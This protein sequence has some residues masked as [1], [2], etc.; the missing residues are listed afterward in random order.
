ME[1]AIIDLPVA[2]DNRTM[3][4]MEVAAAIE[5]R[6]L[7][8]EFTKAVLVP[9]KDYGIIPGTEKYTLLKPGAEKLSSYFGFSVRF[10]ILEAEKDWTGEKHNHEPF[11]HYE[12]RCILYHGEK[13]IAEGF[14]ACNSWE[15]KFRYRSARRIC[16]LCQ[17]PA[18]IKSKYNGGFYCNPK[19]NGCGRKFHANDP[20]IINQEEGK[21]NNPDIADQVNTIL[22]I[23]KKRAFIDAI[24]IAVNASEFFTQDLED[25]EY[26]G[27]ASGETTETT[28]TPET[29]N[30]ISQLQAKLNDLKLIKYESAYFRYLREKY[31]LASAD[32]INQQQFQEQIGLLGQCE[33][34]KTKLK[35]LEK[36]LKNIN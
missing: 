9:N 11:F 5:R 13:I 34:N 4:V 33:G 10:E 28:T 32:D 36:Y 30:L 21:V 14:G 31:E 8:V 2:L 12:I 22:K 15:K 3:P 18:I 16:P 29:D 25:L 35:Q 24:L 27:V 17:Q 7:L 19:I 26:N 6:K 20:Q 1:S 23:A